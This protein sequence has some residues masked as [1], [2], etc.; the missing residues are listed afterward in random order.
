LDPNLL[1]FGS[2]LNH[3]IKKVGMMKYC[4]LP[5]FSGYW[6]ASKQAN[7]LS[8]DWVYMGDIKH[9]FLYG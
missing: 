3:A 5:E 6:V 8:I 7:P 1:I 9:E 2:D 4:I